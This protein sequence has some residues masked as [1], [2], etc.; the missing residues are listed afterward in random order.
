MPDHGERKQQVQHLRK[1][2][3]TYGV[4]RVRDNAGRDVVAAMVNAIKAVEALTT[5]GRVG[6]HGG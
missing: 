2:A 5:E 4:K 3:G 1:L 6:G